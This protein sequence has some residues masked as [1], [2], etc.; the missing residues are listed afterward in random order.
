MQISCVVPVYNNERTI[1]RVLNVL[2]KCKYLTEVVVVN[3]GSSDESAT[4]IA[5]FKSA[6]KLKYLDNK[7]NRGKGYTVVR[8]IKQS[9]GDVIFICDADLGKLQLYHI[10]KIINRFLEGDVDMVIAARETLHGFLTSLSGERIFWKKNLAEFLP[11]ISESGNGIEQ[12][13]NFA[14]R[15]KKVVTILNKNIGHVLKYERPNVPEWIR[16][17]IQE[18]SQLAKTEFKLR[19]LVVNHRLSKVKQKYSSLV[20]RF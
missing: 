18:G 19:K 15:H 13:I 14:H 4:I 7:Q 16:E 10:E 6:K 12:I 17:Y 8:G 5:T 11:M 9:K 3:D 1:Q 20:S 2:L